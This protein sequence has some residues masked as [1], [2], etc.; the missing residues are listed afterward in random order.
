M[1]LTL[2]SEGFAADVFLLLVSVPLVTGEVVA[3]LAEACLQG[4]GLDG[5]LAIAD[6]SCSACVV[7]ASDLIGAHFDGLLLADL[8]CL[9]PRNDANLRVLALLDTIVFANF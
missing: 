2:G 1:G 8:L 9:W 3:S 4:G 7:L 5:G 6:E